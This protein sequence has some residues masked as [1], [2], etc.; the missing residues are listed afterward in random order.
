MSKIVENVLI[1]QGGGPICLR[2]FRSELEKPVIPYWQLVKLGLWDLLKSRLC[3]L[4][5]L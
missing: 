2:H 5:G 3:V 4:I 1:L